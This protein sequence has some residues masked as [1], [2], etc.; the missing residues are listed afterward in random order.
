MEKKYTQEEITAIAD[1]AI[2]KANLKSGKELDLDEMEKVSGGAA[3]THQEID[4]KCDAVQLIMDEYGLD[5]G[6]LMAEKLGIVPDELSGWNWNTRKFKTG[7]VYELRKYLHDKLD[8]K[9]TQVP[10]II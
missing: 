6:Q 7:N 1:E 3:L 10:N 4:E 9:A 5:V 2:R 8:G